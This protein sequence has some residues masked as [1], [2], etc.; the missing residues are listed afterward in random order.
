MIAVTVGIIFVL[1]VAVI[2]I[3]TEPDDDWGNW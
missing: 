2:F 3:M 1:C